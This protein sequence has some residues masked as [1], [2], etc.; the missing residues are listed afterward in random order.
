M[1]E[2]RTFGGLHLFC[3]GEP[4]EELTS[5]KAEALLVYLAVT[6]KPQ[7]RE[8]LSDFFWDTRTQSQAM[9]NLRTVLTIL[10]KRVGKYLSIGRNYVRINP[11]VDVWLDLNEFEN[12]LVEAKLEEAINLYKGDF[13]EGFHIRDSEGFDVWIR[14]ERQYCLRR[15]QDGLHEWVSYH[16]QR[17]SYK[18]GIGFAE[19]LLVVDPLDEDA[20]SQLILLLSLTGQQAAAVR[21]YEEYCRLLDLELGVE[22]TPETQEQF[23]LIRAG[24]IEN[25]LEMAQLVERESRQVGL[26]P[27]RGLAPFREVDAPFFHGRETITEVLFEKL[28][29]HSPLAVI[30]GP[31]GSGKSSIV[32]AGLFPEL[33]KTGGWR[34]IVMR[35][36]RQPFEKLA[37]TMIPILKPDLSESE[38]LIETDKLAV[39][40]QNEGGAI[41]SVLSQ[42][43]AREEKTSRLLL[44]I[45]QFEELYTLCMDSEIQLQFLKNLISTVDATGKEQPAPVVLLQTLRADFMGQALTHRPFADL[46]QD[47]VFVLG[48]MLRSELQ[49]AIEKP[50]EKQGAAFEPGLVERILDDVGEEPGNLPLVEFALT[51]L[52]DRLDQGWI[53]HAAYEEIGR[54][55]GALTSYAEEV[56][57][58]LN[59]KQKIGAHRIFVQLVQP[60]DGLEDTRRIANIDELGG[61]N[62][63]LVQHLADKRLV[64]TG[65]DEEGNKTVEIVHEALINNWE[66]MSGWMEE[67]REFR[68]WQERT[69]VAIQEWE[70]N[71]RDQGGLLRGKPLVQS[72]IW[73]DERGDELGKTE[74]EFIQ[75]S[76]DLREQKQAES[77]RRRR[78]IFAGLG[79][80]VLITL[81]LALFSYNQRNNA[82]AS[83]SVSLAAHVENALE[84]NEVDTALAL[85]LEAAE[86]GSP[87]PAV[88]RVLRQATYRPGPVE[89]ISVQETF[90]IDGDIFSLAVSPT[91][92][93]SLIGF[94][95]GTI[96]LWDIESRQEIRQFHGHNDV[97]RDVTF[98][99]DGKTA[100]SASHDASVILW[101]LDTGKML[102][103]FNGHRGWVRTVAFS[104]DGSTAVSGGFDGSSEDTITNPGE[105]ILWDLDQGQEI[106][107]FSGHPSGVQ[108]AV[109]TP[110][111]QQILASS[112]FFVDFQNEFSLILWDVKDGEM[113]QNFP[114]END[115]YALAISPDGKSA[116]SG[117]NFGDIYRWDLES[118]EQT[119]IL[120]GHDG[121][122]RSL[123]YTS[124]GSR[125]ISI[126]SNGNLILW[127]AVSGEILMRAKIHHAGGEGWS[128]SRIP[129]VQV[130]VGPMN[131]L[132]VTS[133]ED[134]TLVI[135]DLSDPAELRRLVG[136]Q[137][138]VAG[139]ALTPDGK[140]A[141]TGSGSLDIGGEPAQ[142]NSLRLWDVETG[143]LLQV[144]EGHTNSVVMVDITQDGRRAL[145]GSGDGTMRWWD[146]ENGL[147]L[148]RFDAHSGGV[149]AIAFSPNEKAALSGSM[150]SS[151]FPDDGIRLWDLE[152]GEMLNEWVGR[153]NSTS[154]IFN[155]DESTAFASSG[156]LQLLDIE[157]G[158]I[159]DTY[160]DEC[161]TGLAITSDRKMAYIVDNHDTV[162]RSID[163]ETKQIIQEFGPHGGVRTRIALSGDDQVLLSS[164]MNGNL[165]L[166]DVD[167]GEVIREFNANFLILDIDMNAD[168]TIGISPGPNNSAILWRLDLP[169]NVTELRKWIA[170]NRYVRDLSC[171]ER[172]TYSIEPLCE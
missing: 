120:Q 61:K 82:L 80:A 98:S 128:V 3:D 154:V 4:I 140:Y 54:V 8:V 43:L 16:F 139:V 147:E 152:T 53:T 122:V 144:L 1:L 63:D 103:K 157:T 49:A 24:E 37:A 129:M 110:D 89:R 92:G 158:E 36:G 72:E 95:D 35:P 38:R 96:L 64:V 40:L 112:G 48:P 156:G 161:C 10:R 71:T 30:V 166:W 124:D 148:Q 45:D 41:F 151:T 59:E 57:A 14:Q 17:G 97:V 83:Y 142:D 91:E 18:E 11:D 6:G 118:Q 15:L 165:Y 168:G 101:D 21:R 47:A 29:Q 13:L 5:R 134:R 159:I 23:R 39:M 104:P 171:E 125:I 69:R 132:A 7:A 114:V 169:S 102:Q 146:L 27:Y 76:L 150:S 66:R 88:Q 26:C 94:D 84:A 73:L 135:W 19:Q 25:P 119:G 126:D 50:A 145:S 100:L 99:P 28:E 123:A 131:R 111:G 77:A 164:G 149:F 81:A 113:I 56:F 115:H 86:V 12:K 170:E 143:E 79:V 155:P 153:A 130:A 93:V 78:L 116:I 90:G 60:G 127:D 137:A 20:L 62:W 52:W 107:R 58:N 34:I 136:H 22:P 2:I 9:A 46:L 55:S 160:T 42:I 31:S 105:L 67:D 65:S 87:P 70:T 32:Y 51:L 133:A 138:P 109:F 167:T 108:E 85:A 44:V 106:R 162:V 74:K 117:S 163:L 141:L 33:R 75:A 172:L 121:M 68:G